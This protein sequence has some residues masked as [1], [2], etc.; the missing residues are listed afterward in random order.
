MIMHCLI[1]FITTA[2][3]GQPSKKPVQ[4]A[5]TISVPIL[6]CSQPLRDSLPLSVQKTA[7]LGRF[8]PK[9]FET[10]QLARR[11]PCKLH[12]GIKRARQRNLLD[13]LILK[14]VQCAKNLIGAIDLISGV[15][16]YL[17]Q[18]TSLNKLF[19]I[20]PGGFERHS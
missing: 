20:L 11:L 2:I 1:S 7:L 10:R 9:I 17:T 5:P 12:I 14:I 8:A 6:G 18:D 19:N 15:P 13:G 16:G 3:M 4:D